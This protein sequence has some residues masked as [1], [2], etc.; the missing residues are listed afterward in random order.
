VQRTL[1]AEKLL[2]RIGARRP[3]SAAPQEYV[4]HDADDATPPP[5][6]VL[7]GATDLTPLAEFVAD[8]ASK[9][10]AV[11]HF[12]RIQFGGGLLAWEHMEAWIL[13]QAERDGYPT[14]WLSDL[15]VPRA[16]VTNELLEG[17][18]SQVQPLEI[19]ARQVIEKATFRK[20]AYTVPPDVEGREIPTADGV[21]EPDAGEQRFIVGDD[22]MLVPLDRPPKSVLEPLRRLSIR[23]TH[24]Y[25]WDEAEAT[26]FVL[27]G[28]TPVHSPITDTFQFRNLP[29]IP[30]VVLTIEV[31]ASAAEVAKYYEQVRRDI[32]G[33]QT[34][35][36]DTL[37]KQ[38]RLARFAATRPNN[39][40]WETRMAAWNQDPQ[41]ARWPI[42]QTSNFQRDYNRSLWWLRWL[43]PAAR[44]RG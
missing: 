44:R 2:A 28:K 19:D 35:H 9:D 22:G 42:R 6:R 8:E 3:Q 5:R 10:E 12:R 31:L 14:W 24:E 25:G 36:R 43:R 15:P 1:E 41:H 11:Q 33:S 37:K 32:I 4:S 34:W 40:T 30:R 20:L 23:L 26:V 13:E 7:T 21:L 38:I 39:E 16:Y 17:T 27:T 29:A 18:T